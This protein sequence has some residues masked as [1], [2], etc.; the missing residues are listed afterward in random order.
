MRDSILFAALFAVLPAP[1]R[2]AQNQA[3]AAGFRA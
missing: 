3:E 1:M 2:E